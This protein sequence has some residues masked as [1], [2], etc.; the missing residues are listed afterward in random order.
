MKKYELIKKYPGSFEKG[1]IVERD[2]YGQYVTK[3][4]ADLFIFQDYE[5]EPFPEFWQ[6]IKQEPKVWFCL[7]E[8]TWEISEA[9]RPDTEMT[10]KEYNKEWVWFDNKKE[11][12]QF[13]L[14]NNP[15]FTGKDMKEFAI[16]HMADEWDSETSLKNWLYDRQERKQTNK[17][18]S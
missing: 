9:I 13:V 18:N 11:R 4:G 12:D 8:E 1:T 17:K 7:N 10:S 6:E 5:I 16:Y 2:K 14:D 15:Q 3:D